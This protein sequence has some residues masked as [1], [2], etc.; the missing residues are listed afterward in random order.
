MAMLEHTLYIITIANI[1]AQ[2][3]QVSIGLITFEPEKMVNPLSRES[4]SS[5]SKHHIRQFID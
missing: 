2:P 1:S 4:Y 3:K 5:A